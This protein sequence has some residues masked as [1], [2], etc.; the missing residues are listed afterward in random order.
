MNHLSFDFVSAITPMGRWKAFLL[1][2]CMVSKQRTHTRASL[3]RYFSLHFLLQHPAQYTCH[4]KRTTMKATPIHSSGHTERKAEWKLFR[5]HPDM[6]VRPRAAATAA[7]AIAAGVA[8]ANHVVWAVNN[9]ILSAGFQSCFNR[10]SLEDLAAGSRM[11]G[12]AEV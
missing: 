2:L 1:P 10:R 6:F 7:A 12:S 11:Q 8:A 5:E 4:R 3:S 9:C